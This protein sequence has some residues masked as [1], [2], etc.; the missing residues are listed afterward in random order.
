[1]DAKP[2]RIGIYGDSQL[3]VTHRVVAGM[4]RYCDEAGGFALRDFRLSGLSLDLANE[5]QLWKGKVDGVVLSVGRGKATSAEVADW[6]VA[7]G[8]PAVSTTSDWFDPR[9]PSFIVDRPSVAE[10]AAQHLIDCGCA[11]FLFFGFEDSAGSQARA[12][13][14]RTALAGRRLKLAEC[15]TG[16]HYTGGFED[17]APAQAEDGLLKA[18]RSMRKPIGVWTVND[19]FAN[20]VCIACEQMGFD[21][22]QEV[23]VLGADDL[24][25]ARFRQPR[26]SSIRTPGEEVGYRAMRTL[27]QMIRGNTR[28]VRPLTEVPATEL[29]ARESTVG[30]R[31]SAG[32]LDDI[33]SYIA[34]NACAGISVDQLVDVAG[35]SRRSFEKWFQEAVGHSPGEE[36]MRVRLERAKHLLQTTDL[37]MGRISSMVGYANSPAFTRFFRN[38]TGKSPKQFRSS[39]ARA[40][41]EA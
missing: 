23:K 26:I 4:M 10:L 24:A 16:H 3:E 17:R 7:G 31:Q 11:S 15:C 1:M 29:I 5:P 27:H 40:S 21:V 18:F 25:I 34:R 19:V 9:V 12:A 20:A 13:A 22:P 37:S 33:K 6:V 38:L 2:L 28:A 36:I 35:T 39:P 32:N 8:T 14:L 30:A 41:A